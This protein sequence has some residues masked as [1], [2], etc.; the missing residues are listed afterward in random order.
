MTTLEVPITRELLSCKP[1]ICRVRSGWLAG[2]PDGF[3]YRFAVVA[4][5]DEEARQAF[6]EA[7]TLWAELDERVRRDRETRRSS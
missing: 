5:T 2:A 7:L 1:D 3:P 6:Q 4:P